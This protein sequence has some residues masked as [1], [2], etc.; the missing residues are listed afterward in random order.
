MFTKIIGQICPLTLKPTGSDCQ[1]W[2]VW[3]FM[4]K[5]S[6]FKSFNH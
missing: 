3:I 4:F 5:L 1:L 2:L 6:S